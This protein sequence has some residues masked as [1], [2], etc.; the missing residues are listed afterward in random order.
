[1][2][3]VDVCVNAWILYDSRQFIGWRDRYVFYWCRVGAGWCTL[4]CRYGRFYGFPAL[5]LG[6]SNGRK[7]RRMRWEFRKDRIE[8]RVGRLMKCYT[9]DGVRS[10][11]RVLRR[12]NGW[13]RCV[14]SLFKTSKARMEKRCGWI[15]GGIN[16]ITLLYF[17]DK[18]TRFEKIKIIHETETHAWLVAN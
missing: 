13:R 14:C 16:A 6:V 15:R 7:L 17:K 12:E 9:I 5:E 4:E 3:S 2:M 8:F 10:D 18:D 1:M 11:M